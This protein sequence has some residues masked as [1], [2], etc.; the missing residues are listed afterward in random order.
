MTARPHRA[1]V[2]VLYCDVDSMRQA[3]YGAYM[4]WFEVGRAE[5]M[6]AQG[7]AYREVE[8]RGFF[9][10][11]SEAFCKYLKPIRYDDFIY[12]ETAPDLVRNASVRFG[13]RLLDEQ[14]NVAAQGYT[15]HPCMDGQGRIVRIPDF[16]K[17]TL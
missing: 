16:L 5:Y 2:R 7:L 13:Y 1:G 11:V 17:E 12:V 3:Y 6:R 14:D 9:L 4:R 15:L 8:D 10:P